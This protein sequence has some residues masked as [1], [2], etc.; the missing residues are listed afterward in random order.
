MADDSGRL[1]VAGWVIKK[2]V[3]CGGW[4]GLRRTGCG[5]QACRR[6]LAWAFRTIGDVDPRARQIGAATMGLGRA[7]RRRACE[8]ACG[9]DVECVETVGRGAVRVGLF[10]LCVWCTGWSDEQRTAQPAGR[11]GPDLITESRLRPGHGGGGSLIGRPSE[12]SHSWADAGA[13]GG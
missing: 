5:A 7:R 9:T 6:L 2:R 10:E 4:S 11:P 3:E 12:S 13:G 1:S 8:L